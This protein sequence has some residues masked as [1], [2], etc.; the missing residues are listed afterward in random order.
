MGD[1]NVVLAEAEVMSGEADVEA[2]ADDDNIQYHLYTINRGDNTMTYKVAVQV[3][4]NQKENSKLS[5]TAPVHNAV[6]VLNSP[7]SGQLYVLG[8]SSANDVVTLESAKTISSHVTKLQIEGSES[9]VGT[10]KVNCITLSFYII[11]NFL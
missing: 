3:A 8:N 11:I 5:I 4:E 6:Q 1:E 9:T 2:E 7:L 10:K